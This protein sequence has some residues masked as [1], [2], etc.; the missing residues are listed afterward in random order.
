[1]KYNFHRHLANWC[2]FLNLASIIG[3]N[4]GSV[5]ELGYFV[6]YRDTPLLRANL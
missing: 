1:M 3:I 4:H 5:T 2:H 6:P